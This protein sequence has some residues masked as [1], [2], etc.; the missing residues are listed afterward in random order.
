MPRRIERQLQAWA[1][2]PGAG[3]AFCNVQSFDED[4]PRG[5][6]PHLSGDYNGYI[7]GH[8]L[9]GP[10][11]ISSTLM[12]RREAFERVGGFSSLPTDEDYELTLRLARCYSASYA[13]DPLV[14]LRQHPGRISLRQREMPMR[15]YL[16]I[17]K[18]FLAQHPN[19]SRSAKARARLGLANVN[20]KLGHFYLQEGERVKARRHLAAFVA[21]RPLDRR[22]PAAM[23][24]YWCMLVVRGRQAT[25]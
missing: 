5:D 20:L 9:E 16:R 1:A 4:G 21:L 8:V 10:K 18:A 14:M 12:V 2:T 23:F 15:Y 11:A 13:S 25:G 19:L 3:F 24:H 17:V 7:L 6:S 22:A